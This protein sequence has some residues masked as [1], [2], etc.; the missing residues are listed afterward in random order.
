MSP[1]QEAVKKLLLIIAALLASLTALAAMLPLWFGWQAEIAYSSLLQKIGKNDDWLV[2]RD[3]HYRRG[4]LSSTATMTVAVVGVPASFSVTNRIDHGPF[5]FNDDFR[6]M[7]VLAS[8]HSRIHTATPLL[9]NFPPIENR[10]LI[11][12]S[13]S[14]DTHIELPPYQQSTPDFSLNWQGLTLNIAVS[15]DRNNVKIDLLVP[16]LLVKSP[17]GTLTATQLTLEA[18]GLEGLSGLVTGGLTL[19]IDRLSVGGVAGNLGLDNFRLASSIKESGGQLT[20]DATGQFRKI[21]DGARSVGPGHLALQLRKLDAASVI[22][23]RKELGSL[24]KQK[25]SPEQTASL[26]LRKTLEL[27]AQLAKKSPEFE[28]TQFSVLANEDKMG[29]HAKF[30]LDG[31][32]TNIG[33]SPAPLLLAVRGDLEF[34]IPSNVLKQWLS[35]LIWKDIHAHRLSG[36]LSTQEIAQISPQAMDQIIDQAYPLYLAKNE[37]GRL[38]VEDKGRYKIHASIRRGQLLVNNKP[39]HG[40]LARLP[41]P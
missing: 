40:T 19:A 3:T 18:D 32:K 2:I 35:P 5:P 16:R 4:W 27:A 28:V 8:I 9:K 12:L 31:G 20:A 15:A 14:S 26:R 37:L 7:P 34:S 24:Q 23:Y 13:G 36:A 11:H 41:L 17:A 22:K 30:I 6:L 21:T 29:G 38:L 1:R 25:L 39:W 10:T 33:A